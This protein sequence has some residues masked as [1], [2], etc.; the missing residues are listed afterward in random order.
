[1]TIVASVYWR[2]RC[3]RHSRIVALALRWFNEVGR[4]RQCGPDRTRTARTV[5]D[6]GERTYG[7]AVSGRRPQ[8]EPRL[9]PAQISF[10]SQRGN[11]ESRA[12]PA[13]GRGGSRRRPPNPA[14]RRLRSPARPRNPRRSP[15]R[16]ARPRPA[17]HAG[18]AGSS[19][20]APVKSLQ[21]VYMYLTYRPPASFHPAQIPRQNRPEIAARSRA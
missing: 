17:C 12:N 7:R 19:P 15:P 18:V 3:S 21:I 16:P 20:V 10:V 5:A 8:R 2:R 9:H 4:R 6:M 14:R 1:M 11:G 13:G